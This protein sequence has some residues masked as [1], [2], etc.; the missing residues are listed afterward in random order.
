MLHHDDYCE[1]LSFRTALRRFLHWSESQAQDH[2]LTA[3][4]HQLLLAIAGT[5]D[6]RGPTVGDVAASLLLKHHSAVGLVDRA[7]AGRLLRRRPDPDD[8]R[9]VRLELT[10]LGRRRLESLTEVHVEELSRLAPVLSRSLSVSDA[11]PAR[12][13]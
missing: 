6:P 4:Q 5:D 7:E 13:R 2:G 1:L 8:H 9:V 11:K 12:S 3:A 10:A